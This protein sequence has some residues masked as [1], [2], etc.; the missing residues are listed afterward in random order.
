MLL[1]R[2]DVVDWLVPVLVTLAGMFGLSALVVVLAA[3]LPA[4]LFKDLAGFAV[5]CSTLARRLLHR[6]LG[7]PPASIAAAS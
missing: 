7:T 5:A 2:G 3:R 4:G 6:L 1:L